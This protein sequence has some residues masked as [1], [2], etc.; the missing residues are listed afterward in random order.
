MSRCAR[1]RLIPSRLAASLSTR[2]RASA[3]ST[4]KFCVRG[5]LFRLDDEPLLTPAQKAAGLEDAAVR[6]F[7]FLIEELL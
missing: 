5:C 4:V 2:S 7:A 1:L 6:L 3:G